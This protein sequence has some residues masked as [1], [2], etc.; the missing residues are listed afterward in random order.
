[1]ITEG[2]GDLALA[3]VVSTART[4]ES[5][6]RLAENVV[7]VIKQIRTSGVTSLRGI[8][9]VLN[10]RSAARRAVT[11]VGNLLAR[12]STALHGSTR[13]KVPNGTWDFDMRQIG[14]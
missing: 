1:M 5:A 8:A 7:Q 12:A 13:A 9:A 11:Q 2:L 6:Q 14:K 10:V 4:A 3:Q